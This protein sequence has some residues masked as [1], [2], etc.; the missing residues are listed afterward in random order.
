[1]DVI[2]ADCEVSHM[3]EVCWLC[4]AAKG[5]TRAQYVTNYGTQA[6]WTPGDKRGHGMYNL[7]IVGMPLPKEVYN[8][9]FTASAGS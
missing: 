3:E 8:D 2:C 1:V 9:E 4:G 7:E 6:M 5:L